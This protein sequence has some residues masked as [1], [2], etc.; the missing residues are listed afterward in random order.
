MR[1][2]VVAIVLVSAFALQT[3]AQLRPVSSRSRFVLSSYHVHEDRY[4]VNLVTIHHD[5]TVVIVIPG[6]TLFRARPGERFCVALGEHCSKFRL[7]SVDVRNQ[8]AVIEVDAPI[9]RGL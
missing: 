9:P 6:P 4:S 7:I 1:A 8:R 3:A 2:V 5:S